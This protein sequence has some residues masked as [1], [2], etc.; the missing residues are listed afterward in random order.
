M[1]RSNSMAPQHPAAGLIAGAT[2]D[3]NLMLRG[4]RGTLQRAEPGVAWAEHW[5]LRGRFDFDTR[6]LHWGLP[7][8]PAITSTPGLWIGIA[9]T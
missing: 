1:R 3:L 2:R 9:S 8:G 4:V 6:T 7:D 5:P